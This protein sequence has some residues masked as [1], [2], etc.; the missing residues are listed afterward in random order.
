M[1][2]LSNIKERLARQNGG[3]Q[4]IVVA[5][6]CKIEHW[7][8]NTE[9]HVARNLDNFPRSGQIVPFV[10]RTRERRVVVATFSTILSIVHRHGAR[11][12]YFLHLELRNINVVLI[13]VKLITPTLRHP[14]HTR[15]TPNCTSKFLHGSIPL[16]TYKTQPPPCRMLPHS[17]NTQQL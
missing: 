14:P 7:S 1:L 15:S 6:Q 17:R 16:L 4:Y 8:A 10:N 11:W 12:I 5:R 9:A 2:L 13:I 3:L